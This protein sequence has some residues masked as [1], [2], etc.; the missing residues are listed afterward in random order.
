MTRLRL[1]RLAVLL[2]FAF[3]LPLGPADAARSCDTIVL[4]TGLGFSSPTAVESFNP[5]LVTALAAQQVSHL[6]LQPM[7]ELTPNY[8]IDFSRSIASAVDVS[9]NN[10]TYRVTLRPWLWSDGVAMTAHD[11]AYGYRLI[12]QIGHIYPDYGAGGVPNLVRSFTVLNDQQFEVRTTRPVNPLWFELNGLNLIYALPEHVWGNV[13]TDELWRRQSDPSFFAVSDGPFIL[14]HLALSRYVSFTPNPQYSG[15][16]SQIGRVVFDFLQ[17]GDAL[18]AFATGEVDLTDVPYALLP[19]IQAMPDVRMVQTHPA[20]TYFTLSLNFANPA[21]DFFHDLRVRQ[22]LADALDQ[23]TMIDVIFHGD[24]TP[25]HSPVPPRPDTFLSPSAR[26]GQFPVDYD[27]ARARELLREAGFTPGPNGILQKNGRPLAF[28]VLLS[29]G[30]STGP[31]IAQFMQRDYAKLG[32]DMQIKQM[33]FN[34][35]LA[36]AFGN[37]HGWQSMYIGWTINGYPDGQQIFSTKGA[38]NISHY[39]DTHMDALVDAVN[40]GDGLAPLFA[41]Q[42]YAAQQQPSIFFSDG[43]APVVARRGIGGTADLID[44]DG[45]LHPERLTITDPGFCHAAHDRKPS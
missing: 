18:Q 29:T 22:A 12:R 8:T 31:Q 42:D 30:G 36:L 20:F 15:H 23:K 7:F 44:P 35:M 45:T 21:V 33:E 13:S 32:I 25:L 37:P 3:L 1:S 19:K 9:D 38:E 43:Y 40:Y 39:S 28:T 16:K 11:V 2:A 26:A 41:W 4:P 27:P 10:Q 6:I 34:Q 14:E 5:I 17:G 24:G